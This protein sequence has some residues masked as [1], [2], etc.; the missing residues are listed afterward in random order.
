MTYKVTTGPASEP[1]TV[2]EVKDYLKVDSS[3]DDT[4]IGTLITAARQ[5]VENHCAIALLPQ[6]AIQIWGTLGGEMNLA[7]SPLRSVSAI[8]Y[9]DA[10]GT[11]QTLAASV[12]SVDSISTPARV[13]LAY[14]QTWPS[15]YDTTNA[16][17]AIFT[18]GYDAASAVPAAIK[19]ALMLTIADM[20][21]NRT[22]YVKRLPTAAEY[23]LQSCGYRVW[24]FQ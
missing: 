18:A 22:D 4:L 21:D 2:S 13:N 16:A 17:S 5:W 1:L 14:G 3:A 8:T 23:L 11:Q 15:T 9:L 20:Y 6:T 10:G 24:L 7:L 19:Q 12:Y